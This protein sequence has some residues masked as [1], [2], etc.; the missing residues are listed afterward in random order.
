MAVE[1]Y[2]ASPSMVRSNPFG[3]FLMILL[4]LAGIYVAVAAQHLTELVGLPEGSRKIVGAAGIVLAVFGFGR[5]ML[6]WIAT[7]FDH[8]KITDDE[9]IWTHGLI[10]KQYTEINMSSVRTVRV[11]QSLLQRIMNAGDVTIYT[12]GDDPELVVRGLP[13]PD[14]IREQVKGARPEE[15]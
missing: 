12:S 15:E 14:V 11:S 9:I 3:T 2:E 7:K 6:W 1:L 8:L 13:D 4:I 5:L 10:S